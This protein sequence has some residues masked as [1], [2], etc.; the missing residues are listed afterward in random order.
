MEER[1]EE[2]GDNEEDGRVLK[3]MRGRTEANILCLHS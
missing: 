1:D 3:T 2:V